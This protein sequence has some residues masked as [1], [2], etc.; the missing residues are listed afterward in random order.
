MTENTADDRSG[1]GSVGDQP[2]GGRRPRREPPLAAA[3]R[4]LAAE[5]AAQKAA[6]VAGA[7]APP[8]PGQTFAPPAA[9]GP[10]PPPP[11]PPAPPAPPAP[12]YAYYPPPAAPA[13]AGSPSQVLM[14]PVYSPWW[15]RVCAALID[16]VTLSIPN[17]V[18]SSLLGGNAL[19]TDP[20]TGLDTFHP[21]A[22]YIA[23]FIIGTVGGLAYYVIME[24]GPRAATVGKMAMHIT[25]RDDS[26]WAPI[27][28]G[29]ALGRRVLGMALWWLLLIPGLLDV[30]CPLWDGRRQ[31]WHDKAV[32]SVVVDKA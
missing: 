23:A 22:G 6:G 16:V 26:T 19:R 11:V 21:T 31:T 12:A 29:R 3:A 30:L 17:G 28:Y 8:P 20:N 5:K 10:A 15:K 7:P 25:V 14:D 18:V 4:Q 24:G 2:D 27:G 32:H 13:I 9:P 1:S